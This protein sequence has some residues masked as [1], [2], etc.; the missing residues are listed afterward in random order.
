MKKQSANLQAAKKITA[1][2]ALLSA[3][4]KL[5]TTSK[6]LTLLQFRESKKQ[7][8]GRRFLLQEKILA[9]SIFKLSPKA[10]RF[11]RRIL[12]LPAPQTLSKLISQANIEPGINNKISS[13]LKSA[14]D[15]MKPEQKLCILLFDEMY[16]K[17][18]LSYND[19]KDTTVGFVTDGVTTKSE[20]ADHA[21]VQIILILSQN[22]NINL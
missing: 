8:K 16:L 3:M 10:Y 4:E 15:K 13:Q 11:L 21:Q 7:K 6:L 20:Y 19:K 1:N 12:I 5:P 2:P 22:N 9:L 14:A 18:N 17:A